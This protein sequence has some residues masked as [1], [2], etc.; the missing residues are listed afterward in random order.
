MEYFSLIERRHSVR[1]YKSDNVEEEKLNK[2]LEAGRLAPTAANRQ[3]YKIVVIRSEKNKETLRKIYNRDWFVNAPIVIGVCSV[4]DEAWVNADGKNY[5]DVDAAIVMDHMILAATD[6]GLG[7]C[8]VGAF[9]VKNA[10][11]LLQLEPGLEPVAFTPVGYTVEASYKK[12]R[13]DLSEIII[14]K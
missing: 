4:T 1:S 14:N 8:W 3:A 13:N 6:L 7:T 2:I 11:E 12:I 5:G 9:D 10:K